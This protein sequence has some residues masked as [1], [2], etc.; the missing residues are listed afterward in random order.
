[1]Q[2]DVVVTELVVHI[3]KVDSHQS[4]GIIT[5][6][7]IYL[8]YI[9]FSSFYVVGVGGCIMLLSSMTMPMR[10]SVIAVMKCAAMILLGYGMVVVVF[11][12]VVVIV[13]VILEAVVVMVVVVMAY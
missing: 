6:I 9:P 1:M 8:Y 13:I 5:N 12:F 4:I 3:L 10:V 2:K 7:S 11:Y